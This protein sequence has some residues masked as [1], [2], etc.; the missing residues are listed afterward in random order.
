MAIDLAI[1]AATRLLTTA[2]QTTDAS[3][4]LS[5]QNIYTHARARLTLCDVR[6]AAGYTSDQIDTLVTA[7]MST[8]RVFETSPTVVQEACDS[9]RALVHRCRLKILHPP[10]AAQNYILLYNR[11]SLKTAHTSLDVSPL[12]FSELDSV[13][14]LATVLATYE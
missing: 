2:N 12:V 13:Y 14:A 5:L 4:I 11:I 1:A 10:S 9:M 3:E 6:L 8:G 7:D